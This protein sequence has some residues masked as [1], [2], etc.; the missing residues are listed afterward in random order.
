MA[1]IRVWGSVLMTRNIPEADHCVKYINTL[2]GQ[3]PSPT[4]RTCSAFKAV[5][6]V[7]ELFAFLVDRAES[8]DAEIVETYL[9]GVMIDHRLD[10]PDFKVLALVH[11]RHVDQE[12]RQSIAALFHLIGRAR[13]SQPAVASCRNTWVAGPHFLAVDDVVIAVTHRAVLQPCGIGAGGRLGHTE[14]LRADSSGRDARKILAFFVLPCRAA[15]ES[16]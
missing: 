14:R 3:R 2:F 13:A 8:A 6:K 5:E 7:A 1:S 9:A 15:A 10:R 12:N 16:P 11:R 4:A